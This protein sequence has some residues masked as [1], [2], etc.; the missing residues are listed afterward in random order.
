[1]AEDARRLD[2]PA[3]EARLAHLDEVLG[4]LEADSGATAREALGAV[5]LLTEVYGEA[6]AR[7]LDHA[8]GAL[9]EALA[10]D[11]LLAHL[12][13]L[14]GVHP[15]PPERRAARAVERLRPAVRKRGG[16]L[17]WEGVEGGVARVRVDPG[18]GGCGAGCGSD[19]TDV[20]EVVRAAVLAAAP[21]LTRVEAVTP[22]RTSPPAFVPLAT[23]TL[24]GAA[25]GA[26]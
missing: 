15:E 21:E 2:D 23:L 5:G 19:T 6:L 4:E 8:D 3:V 10:G 11:E 20:A 12:L 18:G 25:Q 13:V 17:E 1:M 22:E 14:H 26:R 9:R 7:V 24:R 16:D